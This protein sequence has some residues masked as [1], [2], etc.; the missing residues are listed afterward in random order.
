[1]QLF[2]FLINIEIL[3]RGCGRSWIYDYEG[4]PNIGEY[5]INFAKF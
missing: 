5:I 2:L 1:M 4:V 3:G